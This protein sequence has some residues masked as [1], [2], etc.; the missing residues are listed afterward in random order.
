MADWEPPPVPRS[1]SWRQHAPGV[2]LN[3]EFGVSLSGRD[4]LHT[5]AINHTSRHL[6]E[7]LYRQQQETYYR[8]HQL[9]LS[10]AQH[11]YETDRQT[12]NLQEQEAHYRD[13]Q[14]AISI[15]HAEYENHRHMR[16]LQQARQRSLGVRP[17]E[18]HER[19]SS[20]PPD[21]INQDV[22]PSGYSVSPMSG[23]QSTSTFQPFPSAPQN[24]SIPPESINRPLPHTPATY[25]LGEAG[26][27]WSVPPWYHPQEV[28]LTSPSL[29]PPTTFRSN[30]P[31]ISPTI[32]VAT[33][34][35]NRSISSG[36]EPWSAEPMRSP[37]WGTENRREEDP[38]RIGEL[39][40][41][42][43]AMMSVDTIQQDG[44]EPWT[45]EDGV[46]DMPRGPRSL[47]WAISTNQVP[48]EIN[49]SST[50]QRYI[51]DQWRP[52]SSG[53]VT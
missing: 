14:L 34:R 19:G 27:P 25:R 46:G 11:E 1:K 53:E 16:D 24:R 31:R 23:Q 13:H 10:I 36:R 41:L 30:P 2:F 40:Q 48:R 8:D 29:S 4:R 43:Q 52:K 38:Q 45:W 3:L 26:L 32:S 6:Q 28:D 9:A 44:W 15:A 42:H 18:Q 37:D 22:P 35:S 20:A 17:L 5:T 51:T 50:P 12:R 49:P 39:A 47:G 21:I 33:S 7:R